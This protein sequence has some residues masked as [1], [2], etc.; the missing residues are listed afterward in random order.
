MLFRSGPGVTAFAPGDAV[1]GVTNPR[2][3]GAYADYAVASAGMIAIKPAGLD[4]I[5]AAAL[6]VVAV[7]AW[8]ALFDQAKLV[9]GQSV[10]ILGAAGNVGA[11][12]VQFARRA[13]LHITATASAGDIDHVRK[14]GADCVIDRNEPLADA[15]HDVDAVIDLVGGE[16]QLQSFKTLRAGGKLISAV[17][18]PD[19]E[20]AKRR[21]VE[22]AFFLVNVTTAALSQL[23]TMIE[24][25]DL[26]TKVGV[27]L[28]L[29]DARQAHEML[30]GT[31]AH[32]AGK[33]VLKI[34]G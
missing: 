20:E 6:P 18:Q 24:A 21:G 14:L 5:E 31:R 9:A 22:A 25:G 27:V 17:S 34:A 7:T 32:P 33:I 30:E 3:I 19:Q 23:A 13:G 29:A 8:Q 11:Y 26:V 28:P 15:V 10:L 16:A 4:V 12:A 2:F 1:Y